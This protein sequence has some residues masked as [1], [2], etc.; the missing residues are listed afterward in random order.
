MYAYIKGVIV[1]I[2]E[3]NVILECNNIGYNIHVPFSVIQMLPQNGTEVKLYTYTCVRED[4]FVLYGFLSK[5]DLW[6][7]KKHCY[8]R[9]RKNN[10]R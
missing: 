8:F 6:I 2:S 7:F 9:K 1:D 4:A 3:D 5:D 10:N